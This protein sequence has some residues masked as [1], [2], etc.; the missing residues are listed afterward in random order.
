M[1]SR[2]TAA[3]RVVENTGWHATAAAIERIHDRFPSFDDR[4]AEGQDVDTTGVA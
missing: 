4:F 1:R 3:S 2:I